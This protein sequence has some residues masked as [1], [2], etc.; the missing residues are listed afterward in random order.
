MNRSRAARAA[1]ASRLTKP[2]QLGFELPADALRLEVQYAEHRLIEPDPEQPRDEPD[3]ELRDS[4]A[5]Q[6]ILQPI[7]VRVHPTKRGH[8]MIV[9]GERRWRGAAGVQAKVP[10]IVRRDQEDELQRLLTQLGANTGLPLTPLEEARAFHRAIELSGKSATEI[11]ELAGRPRSTVGERLGLL[12]LGP[13]QALLEKGELPVSHAV[14]VLV[15]LRG[16]PDAY[17]RHAIETIRKDYRWTQAKGTISIGAFESVVR[18]TYARFMYPLLRSTKSYGKNPEFN[19]KAHDQE[20]ECGTIAFELDYGGKRKCCGNPDWWKPRHRKA[21]AEQKKNAPAKRQQH[22]ARPR[23]VLPEGAPRLKAKVYDP[24]KGMQY[25]T[26]A[27]GLWDV[28]KLECDPAELVIDDAKL[29]LVDVGYGADIV[30]TKDLAAVRTAREAWKARWASRLEA[31]RR[32]LLVQLREHEATGAIVGAGAPALLHAVGELFATALLDLAAVLEVPVPVAVQQANKW[33]RGE[34]VRA[35]LKTLDGPVAERLLT[36]VAVVV[37]RELELPLEQIAKEQDAARKKIQQR[38]IPWLATGKAKKKAK[39]AATTR[40]ARATESE[41]EEELE[42]AGCV[43]CGEVEC[44]G[45][46]SD[47]LFDDAAESEVELEEAVA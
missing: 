30:A 11:A 6:G 26:D 36:S 35:W 5:R 20:C 45:D 22:D 12:E 29:V 13:W 34:K 31:L 14:R 46:C 33:T 2:E 7:T 17:H 15:P 42:E 38:R 40:R 47:D 3:A 32:S 24:P 37:G 44:E 28:A 8:Y 4:I 43:T 18:T 10:V 19:T 27:R 9:D 39:K 16:V 41:D 23:L 21:L 25:L 1:R